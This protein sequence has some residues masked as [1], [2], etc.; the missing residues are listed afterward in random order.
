MIDW[1][2]QYY[3]QDNE[4]VDLF[5]AITNCHGWVKSNATEVVVRLEPISQPKRRA[6]QQQFCRKLTSLCSRL[7]SGKF[8][9]IEVGENPTSKV[10]KK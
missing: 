6:A 1:L 5:Y 4:V 10:S 7:P 9:V 8:M 3:D 2:R